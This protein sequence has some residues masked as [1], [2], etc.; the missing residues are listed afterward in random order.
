MLIAAVAVSYGARWQYLSKV[1]TRLTNDPLVDRVYVVDNASS[2]SVRSAV[3]ECGLGESVEVITNDTNRG[4]AEAFAQGLARVLAAGIYTHVYLLDDDNEPV[5]GAVSAIVEAQISSGDLSAHLSLRRDRVEFAKAEIDGLPVRHR[6]NSFLGYDLAAAVSKR[7]RP[8]GGDATNDSADKVLIEY[9]PYGGL[10]LPTDIVRAVGLPRAEYVLY[11]DDHEFTTRIGR[12]GYPIYLC[13]ASI[14]QD[15][16]KSWHV[17]SEKRNVPALFSPASSEFRVYYS[18]RNRV[19]FEREY[20]VQSVFFY[21]ANAI[22]LIALHSVK[23]VVL[24]VP[25]RLV[26]RRL[27]LIS[28]AAWRGWKH[29]LGVE[30]LFRLQ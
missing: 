20:L 28:R 9:A 4:S 3:Y 15:L 12:A 18:V 19:A 25:F 16:E 24:G 8:N 5:E 21:V 13:K 6:N 22:S 30:P 1:L 27:G 10:F 26:R 29:R 2:P 11:V 17:P 23:A 14:V 7:L